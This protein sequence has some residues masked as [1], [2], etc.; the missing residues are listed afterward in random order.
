MS[1]TTATINGYKAVENLYHRYLTGLIPRTVM[2][3]GGRDAA[4]L[5][6]RLFRRQQQ[7]KFLP[8]VKKLGLDHLP[9]A[10]KCAQY[11]YLSNYLG[12]VNVQYMYESDRKAWVRYPPPR[13]IF[14]GA[15]ICGIPTE[16]SRA[17]M[18]GWH[19]HNGVTLGNPRLGFVCTGQTVDGQ[20]GL[21]GYFYEYDH[22]LEP[23]ERLR[24]APGEVSPEFDPA[25]A[26]SLDSATWPEERLRKALR[27]YAMEYVRNLLPEMIA[28]FGPEEAHHLGRATGKLIGMQY[29]AETARLLNVREN[30]AAAFGEFMAHFGQAAGDDT[31]WAREGDGVAVRQTSWR[32]MRDIP[33]LH[34]AAFDAWNG[35][36]EGALSVHNRRLRLR[37]MQRRDQGGPDYEWIIR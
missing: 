37:V 25:A 7:E 9:D 14:D 24:F 35:L 6:F 32:L 29:Y 5:V 16:V 23:E 19:S 15:A 20:P 11:H 27:N 13:W 4:E 31:A 2:T 33:A 26:P 8:G 18:R 34:P 3:R 28:L 10:V 30:T 1:E 17:M 12:D 36:W 21:E 22:T